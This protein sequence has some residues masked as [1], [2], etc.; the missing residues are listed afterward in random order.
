MLGGW[1]RVWIVLVV[2]LFAFGSIIGL[3]QTQF[4]NELGGK[5]VCFP[6][7]LETRMV[8]EP[9]INNWE[10]LQKTPPEMLERGEILNP[11]VRVEQYSC[12]SWH[13]MLKHWAYAIAAAISLLAFVFVARWV[14]AGFSKVKN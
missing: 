9:T 3:Q 4:E 5:D 2:G 14:G 10:A 1:W 12:V 8:S 7:T 6:G 13:T 11:R